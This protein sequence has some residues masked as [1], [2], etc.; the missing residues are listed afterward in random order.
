[1]WSQI[2]DKPLL[3]FSKLMRGL[4]KVILNPILFF[5]WTDSNCS[6][7]NNL[8][9]QQYNYLCWSSSL[10]LGLGFF[11]DFF[12]FKGGGGVK[13]LFIVDM[14][15]RQAKPNLANKP[16]VEITM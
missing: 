4:L 7:G 5:T 10:L 6:K 1:M 14:W 13:I 15:T 2:F 3:I 9:V 16:K 11:Q 12:I 8:A